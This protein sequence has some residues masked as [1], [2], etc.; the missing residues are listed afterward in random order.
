M[1]FTPTI[2]VPHE[3]G[4]TRQDVEQTLTEYRSES[5]TAED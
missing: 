3:D 1:T 5:D 4:C 2:V